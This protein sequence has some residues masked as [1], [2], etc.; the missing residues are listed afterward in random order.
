MKERRINIDERRINID[1][2]RKKSFD[3]DDEKNK[4][5]IKF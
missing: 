5:G 3:S 2:I 1:R 4:I